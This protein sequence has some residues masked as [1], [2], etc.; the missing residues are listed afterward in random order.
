MKIAITREGL[1]DQRRAD[2]RSI[3]HD[4]AA[5]RLAREC[6]LGDPGHRER[7]EESGDDGKGND[8]HQS[9]AKLSQHDIHPY[10]RPRVVTI[11]SM[12]LMPTNGTMRPPRP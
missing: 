12:I 7:I 11:T 10:A 5:V 2:H 4:E 8:E 3:L 1:A 9:G 6:D